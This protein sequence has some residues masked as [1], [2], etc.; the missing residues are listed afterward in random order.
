[1][2]PVRI[3]I[4][5]SVF[6]SIAVRIARSGSPRAQEIAAELRDADPA[7]DR[8]QQAA[9]G[10]A[11]IVDARAGEVGD[12]EEARRSPQRRATMLEGAAARRHW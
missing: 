10:R 1:M 8:S 6:G 9:E 4:T 5:T 7:P 3:A 12:Y 11:G 2:D